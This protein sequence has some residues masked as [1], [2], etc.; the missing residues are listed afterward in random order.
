VPLFADQVR[1]A[2]IDLGGIFERGSI[3]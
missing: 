3:R 2:G 1:L